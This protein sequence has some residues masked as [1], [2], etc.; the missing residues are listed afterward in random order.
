MNG[1]VLP[2][3]LC[4]GSVRAILLLVLCAS[5]SVGC[6]VREQ[7]EAG[8]WLDDREALFARHSSWSVSGRMALSDGN[9]GGSLAFDWR[10]EG[11]RHE[12]N[13]RTVAG[14]RQWRLS[15]GPDGAMLEGSGIER[16][17][18]LDPD[19]LVEAAIGWPV[20]VREMTWWIRG[21]PPPHSQAVM[22]FASDGALARV[23]SEPWIMVYQRFEQTQAALLPSRLQAD[24]D[25]YRVRLVLRDWQLRA[26]QTHPVSKSL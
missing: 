8:A 16:M 23:E 19:P 18:A 15:F 12:V 13:L 1:A 25:N 21:L 9:R 4:L 17:W 2:R 5:L 10:A 24:S 14:G 11:D 26:S 22:A 3:P 20:P 6:A 7:R